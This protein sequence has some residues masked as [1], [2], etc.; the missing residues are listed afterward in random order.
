MIIFV[1]WGA[2]AQKLGNSIIPSGRT[3][4][5]AGHPSPL[6][7]KRDFIGCDHFVKINEILKSHGN[8]P[9]DWSIYES[10]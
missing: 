8:I 9:I 3:I 4:L 1:L 2:Q 6:N 7:R 10:I 5:N